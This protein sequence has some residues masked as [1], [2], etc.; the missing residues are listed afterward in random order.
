VRIEDIEIH[1]DKPD[2]EYEAVGPVEAKVTAPTAFSQAPT[3]DQVNAKLREEAI[4]L[5]ASAVI[6]VE[7]KRGVT[8][9]SW[10]ALAARG[11]AVVWK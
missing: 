2:R 10:K 7:Y 6:D 8:L 4:A 5:G 11:V 1:V 9:T 3:L